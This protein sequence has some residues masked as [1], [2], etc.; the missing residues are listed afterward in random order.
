MGRIWS[1]EAKF[2]S[3][4][5]VEVSAAEVMAD[6]GIVPKEAAA[7]IRQKAAYSIERIDAN[8]KRSEARRHRLHPSARRERR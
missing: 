1:E 2:D 3:W 7:E 8:R 5:E 6:R 4:M